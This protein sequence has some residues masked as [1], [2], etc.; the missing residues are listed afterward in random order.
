MDAEI[1]YDV[2]RNRYHVYR[3]GELVLENALYH[4]AMMKFIEVCEQLGAVR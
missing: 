4:Q 3:G 2:E 1:C